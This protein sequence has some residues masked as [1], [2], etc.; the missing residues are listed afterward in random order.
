M[1]AKAARDDSCWAVIIVVKGRPYI[2]QWT[3]RS[4][5]TASIRAWMMDYKSDGVRKWR[6]A[7]KAGK[8]RCSRLA[9]LERPDG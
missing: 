8:V 7:R 1:T 5:R 4:R 3:I 6:R 2:A 9:I